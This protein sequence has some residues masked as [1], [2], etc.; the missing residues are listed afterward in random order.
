MCVYV[1]RC[2]CVCARERERVTIRSVM[3]SN[4]RNMNQLMF[5]FHVCLIN[6]HTHT[7][8][9]TDCNTHTHTHTYRQC[10]TRIDLA[11]TKSAVPVCCCCCLGLTEHWV[12]VT[13]EMVYHLRTDPVATELGSFVSEILDDCFFKLMY[14][15]LQYFKC[16]ILI[17][18]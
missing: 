3:I 18:F 9:H 5:A 2:V 7:H 11:Y 4:Y 12:L 13:D 6:A 15:W 17:I 8:T 1:L 14:E 10:N 16:S